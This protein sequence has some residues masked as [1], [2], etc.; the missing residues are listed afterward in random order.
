MSDHISR[1][2]I[3]LAAFGTFAL[4]SPAVAS[5]P[6]APKAVEGVIVQIEGGEVIVDIGLARGVPAGATL[7]IYRRLT[8]RHP[9]SGKEIEDRF[10]IGTLPSHEVGE[11]LTIAPVDHRLAT[12]SPS[13][14]RAPKVGDFAV[15]EP[16]P[17]ATQTSEQVAAETAADTAAVPPPAAEIPADKA[18]LEAVFV[19]NLGRPLPMRIRNWEAYLSAF[20]ESSNV[21]LVGRELA[22]M[23][24]LA[25]LERGEAKPAKPSAPPNLVAR[26]AKPKSVVRGQPIHI[27]VAVANLEYVDRVRL[28]FRPSGEQSYTPV[29]MASDGDVYFRAEIPAALVNDASRFDYYIEAVRTNAALVAIAGRVARPVSVVVVDPPRDPRDHRGR[30][31]ARFRTEYVDFNTG[32]DADDRYLQSEAE[33]T[34]RLDYGRIR[35]IRVGVGMM[36]GEGGKTKV[37]ELDP[38]QTRPLSV[39]YGFAE[40]E[41]EWSTYFGTAF[42]LSGG[43]HHDT[44]TGTAEQI[45]GFEGRL[46]I[47]RAEGTRVVLG[48]A[49]MEDMGNQAFADLHVEAFPQIPIRAGVAATDLPV[50]E[51]MGVRLTADVGWRVRDWVAVYLVGGWN[52]RTIDHHGV[53]GGTAVT[54]NW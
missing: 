52:A 45:L 47:G 28:F 41:I 31:R 51:D 50:N 43:N 30:S 53:T 36:A 21:E 37:I 2:L 25:D 14:R 18:A 29:D 22:R 54:L 16:I 42:R 39:G 4:S 3:G 40:T 24:Q 11:L 44:T 48:A 9:I 5:E 35:D 32:G 46:R 13:L 38:K 12:G 20:P 23:R 6:T 26:H 8:I 19:Q 17:D 49:A 33:F 34:Y 10:P 7:R 1:W 27:V 15:Y